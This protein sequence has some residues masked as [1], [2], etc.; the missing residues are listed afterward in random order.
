MVDVIE[1]DNIYIEY[2]QAKIVRGNT[3]VI[4]PGCN[5]ELV[6]YKNNYTKD[7]E[8][9]VIENRKVEN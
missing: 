4:G 2:T 5:I 3:I 8:S 9:T 7:K 1:G 6:E